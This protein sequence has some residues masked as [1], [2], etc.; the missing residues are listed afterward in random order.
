MAQRMEK[1]QDQFA[2]ERRGVCFA[3]VLAGPASFEAIEEK[4]FLRGR[5]IDITIV[6]GER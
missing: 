6:Y 1:R 3:L 2:F 4:D 5:N